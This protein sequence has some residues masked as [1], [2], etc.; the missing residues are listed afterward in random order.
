[1]WSR[2]KYLHNIAHK[3]SLL[4]L[5]N[6]HMQCSTILIEWNKAQRTFILFTCGIISVISFLTISV[7]LVSYVIE[8]I[9]VAFTELWNAIQDVIKMKWNKLLKCRIILIN[10]H[11][12]FPPLPSFLYV[13]YNL[14]NLFII[15]IISFVFQWQQ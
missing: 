8:K 12:Y 15:Y 6:S 7:F 11:E 5:C 9:T 2:I 4:L 10:L 1:M 3:L 13:F 14:I